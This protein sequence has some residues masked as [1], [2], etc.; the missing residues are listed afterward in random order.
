MI[1][2]PIELVE[3]H[4]AIRDSPSHQHVG[5]IMYEFKN[6]I[7]LGLDGRYIAVIRG[8]LVWKMKK[9]MESIDPLAR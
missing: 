3:L 6:N 1:Q 7:V 2:V 4:D 5:I 8:K 9:F